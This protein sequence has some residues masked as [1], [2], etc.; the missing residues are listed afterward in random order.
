MSAGQHRV[1]TCPLVLTSGVC[2]DQDYS[3][4]RGHYVFGN[5]DRCTQT[6]QEE[7]KHSLEKTFERVDV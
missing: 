3:Q 1:K 6:G 4:G 2:D 7:G 5:S